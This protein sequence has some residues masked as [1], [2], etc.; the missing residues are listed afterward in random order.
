MAATWTY[1]A[2]FTQDRDKIRLLIGDTSEASKLLFDQEISYALTRANNNNILRAAAW[3]CDF[4]ASKFAREKSTSVQGFSVNLSN[5]F[6]HYKALAKK[7]RTMAKTSASLYIVKTR[8]DKLVF[9]S[10][11]DLIPPT[12]RENQFSPNQQI[13]DKSKDALRFCI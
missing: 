7:Y 8:D 13:P 3:A 12:F 2:D 10:N 1:E 6:S 11:P 9:T 4:I 5:I